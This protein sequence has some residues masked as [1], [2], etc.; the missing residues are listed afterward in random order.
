MI[1]E[2]RDAV[3]RE[4]RKRLARD[5][6]DSVVQHVFSVGMQAK[7]LGGMAPRLTDLLAPRVEAAAT[8]V[9]EQRTAR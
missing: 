1:H 9:T 5:L 2:E 3:R 7:A 4:E 8:E 6:H